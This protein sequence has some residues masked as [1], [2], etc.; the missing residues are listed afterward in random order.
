MSDFP[1]TMIELNNVAIT[2]RERKTLFRFDEYHALKDISFK[3]YKGE[4]LGI[5]GRN[6]A[7]KSTLLRLLAGIIE[8]DKGEIKHNTKSVSLM[9]LA[10][11][12]DPNLSGRQNAIISGM[13]MGYRK[14]EVEYVLSEIKNFSELG[15]FFDKP[16]KAYSSGMRA[17]LAFSI[18]MN[19]SPDVLLID[20]VLGVG[21][22]N[23]RQ[24]AELALESKIR[25][26]ITV[27]LVSHSENQVSR[28]SDRI[29]W[30]ENGVVRAV[31]LPDEIYNT[32]NMHLLFSKFGVEVLDCE[33][34]DDYIFQIE[35]LESNESELEFKFNIVIIDKKQR[36]IKSVKLIH[37]NKKDSI[38]LSGP[39]ASPAYFTRYPKYE[40]A[41]CA[42]YRNASL[43]LN[44][45]F[46]II[47][48]HEEG[49]GKML[50][51]EF[52]EVSE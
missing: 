20:E 33:V 43:L 11:G 25:S 2:Y 38:F 28:L 52:G 8:P 31:G 39:S 12:F 36:P 4:T 32:Y 24:K 29:A 23:F 13:L 6:G 18:A 37:D 17:R 50:R 1:K 42:R 5:I 14:R 46:Q 51:I 7:G 9:A 41:K 45:E 19:I 27:V 48:E 35:P 21:D 26:N 22:V 15:E 3:V 16:T 49:I 34:S 44:G 47:I 10:A 40:S 30:I